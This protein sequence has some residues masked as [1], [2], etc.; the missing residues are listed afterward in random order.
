M[1]TLDV[2]QIEP[3]LKHSTIFEKFDALVKNQEFIIQNDHD[4]KPLYFQLLAERGKCF[5]W[6]YLKEGPFIWEIKITKL[7][8][9]DELPTIGEMVAKDYRKAEVFRKFGLDFCCGGNKSLQAACEKKGIDAGKVEEALREVDNTIPGVQQNFN[10]W[11]LDF[12]ADYI[13][14]THHKYIAYAV[15]MLFEFSAKVARVHGDA[16]PE[17]IE[18]ADLFR[19]V[20]EELQLHMQKEE[21][22]LFSY[23]KEMVAARRT[24]IACERPMFGTIKNPISMMEEEHLSAGGNMEEIHRLSNGYTPP[25]DA[26]S[27]FRVLYAKLNEFE[28]DLHQHIHLENNILFPKAIALES[29]LF[30]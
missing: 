30:S 16:H 1:E 23:I 22:I 7:S 13:T 17:T 18:I 9:E 14:N 10:T 15:P 26:C 11:E 21:N 24:G 2:T 12:L 4:P 28:M 6:V 29:E 5:E 27:T 20:A 25:A 3:Y 8:M 19:D